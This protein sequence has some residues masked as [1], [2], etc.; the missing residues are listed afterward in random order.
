MSR[1]KEGAATLSIKP[2]TDFLVRSKDGASA[3]VREWLVV[4]TL[5]GVVFVSCALF[6]VWLYVQQVQNGYRLSKL[7]EENEFHSTVQRKLK[8][9][10]SR[11]RDPYRLEEIGRNQFGLAPPGPEQKVLMR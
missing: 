1:T 2:G 6:Y 11:F 9:E 7:Y 10:W 3:G 4:S 8:L 5:L